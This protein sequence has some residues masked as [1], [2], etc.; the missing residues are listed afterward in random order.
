M[1]RKSFY[2]QK[3]NCK[4]NYHNSAYGYWINR[5]K[6]KWAK[7]GKMGFDQSYP[8]INVK[9]LDDRYEIFLVAPGLKREDFNISLVENEMTILVNNKEKEAKEAGVIWRR[10]EFSFGRFQRRFELNEKIDLASIKAKYGDGILH[11][12]LLKLEGEETNRKD[13]FVN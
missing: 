7:K 5:N 6:E 10:K 1:C 2:H 3:E 4:N 13:I 8:P 12:T 9:E 11:L